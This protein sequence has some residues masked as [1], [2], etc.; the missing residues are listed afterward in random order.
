[1]QRTALSTMRA[2]LLAMVLAIGL[3]PA[4]AFADDSG[5]GGGSSSLVGGTI[6]A[7]GDE[8]S[9]GGAGEDPSADELVENLRW[10]L[11]TEYWLNPS[12]NKGPYSNSASNEPVYGIPCPE[13]TVYT[14][15]DNGTETVVARYGDGSNDSTKSHIVIRH[16]GEEVFDSSTSEGYDSIAIFDEPGFYEIEI[17]GDEYS[18]YSYSIH[19]WDALDIS[20]WAIEF[21]EFGSGMFESSDEVQSAVRVFSGN[22]YT[23]DVSNDNAEFVS[24]ELFEDGRATY[25]KLRVTM[26]EDSGYHGSNSISYGVWKPGVEHST[27]K[28]LYGSELTFGLP[29]GDAQDYALHT[30]KEV[31]VTNPLVR[32]N[33]L[34]L[35]DYR[36]ITEGENYILK[37]YNNVDVGMAEVYAVGIGDFCGFIK[38]TFQIYPRPMEN[39][40]YKTSIDGEIVDWGS[41]WLSFSYS[42]EAIKP[43][44]VITDENGAT[45]HLQTDEQDGDYQLEYGVYTNGNDD[46]FITPG[47]YYVHVIGAGK[48]QGSDYYLSYTI[49]D[50]P[51]YWA[52]DISGFGFVSSQVLYVNEDGELIIDQ[53]VLTDGQKYYFLN[54]GQYIYT[55]KDDQ[56]NQVDTVAAGKTYTVRVEGCA[57]NGYK[58]FVEFASTVASQSLI[59][60]EAC[61]YL[62][63]SWNASNYV[64]ASAGSAEYP[65]FKK[66]GYMDEGADNR[67]VADQDFEYAIY[68][69]VDNAY[70]LVYDNSLLPIGVYQVLIKGKGA[71]GGSTVV[72]FNVCDPKDLSHAVPEYSMYVRAGS[73]SMNPVTSVSI[74]GES[75]AAGNYKVVY[76]AEMDNPDAEG[77]S[78]Y[79]ESTDA[80]TEPG[81]YVFKIASLSYSNE[82]ESDNGDS[83]YHGCSGWFSYEV[84]PSSYKGDLNDESVELDYSSI[85]RQSEGSL[86]P[87]KSI[88]WDDGTKLQA[89]VDYIAEFAVE[90]SDDDNAWSKQVFSDVGDYV[91]RVTGINNYSGELYLHYRVVPSNYIGSLDDFEVTLPGSKTVY[92]SADGNAIEFFQGVNLDGEPLDSKYYSVTYY[93]K[94]EDESLSELDSAPTDVGN[95]TVTISGRDAYDGKYSFDFSIVEPGNISAASVEGGPYQVSRTEGCIPAFV[96]KMDGETLYDSADDDSKNKLSLVIK[97]F[98]YDEDGD[99]IE[100]ETEP[101][102]VPGS[103]IASFKPKA[104]NDLTGDLAYE[105]EVK[106]WGDLGEAEVDFDYVSVDGADKNPIKSVTVDGQQLSLDT[107][108]VLSFYNEYP[109]DMDEKVAQP[110]ELAEG[111]F[112]SD[113]G[114]YWVLIEPTAE[115]GLTGYWSAVYYV[116]KDLEKCNA[117]VSFNRQ[118]YS[119]AA[120]DPKPIVTVDGTQ[121]SYDG[122]DFE[123]YWNV[124]RDI[125]DAGIYEVEVQGYGLYGG[126]VRGTLTV[127]PA[128]IAVPTGRTLTYNAG[129]Q[130]GVAGGAGYSVSGNAAA[131]AGSYTATATCDANHVFSNGSKTVKVGWRINPASINGA[132]V[133]LAAASAAYNG[134]NQAGSVSGVTLGGRTLVNGKD[135]TVSAVRGANVG[136]YAVTVNGKGNYTG[137]KATTFSVTKAGNSA[138]PKK[139]SLKK[140]IKLAKVKKKA[141]KFSLPKVTTKFGKAKWKV[142][143]WGK[144]AK[145]YLKV[146]SGGK[147]TVKKGAMKGT[148]TVKLRANV[149]GTKN[150]NAAKSGV[151]TV[152]VVVK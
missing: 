128:T 114:E 55:V 34:E 54:E 23:I 146:A 84:V 96:V 17:F 20:N 137:S 148:Y 30:G 12:D 1:M 56:G 131:N 124:D 108:Y 73:A 18:T 22:Q 123:Y 125:K 100:I 64:F 116:Y 72:T 99:E 62:D 112:P 65:R 19:I 103:Y 135:F 104:G 130:T 26:R 10:N 8:D 142:A 78:Y 139:M 60:S 48:Y 29:D 143:K 106:N 152:K 147:V 77:A 41:S 53:P 86:N 71:Y 31:Y 83:E 6:S 94:D 145:K 25:Y 129:N 87:V 80:P 75:V 109:M 120:L 37:Y 102:L 13:A 138:K 126:T 45:L 51:E 150:Y 149:A 59:P 151:V 81:P 33:D 15:D 117:T 97:R 132:S 88:T 61:L 101:P 7:M 74:N 49:E 40:T 24:E 119:G 28:S 141:Q 133:S 113:W 67:L 9:D 52:I 2:A 38:C 107:D 110:I 118:V 3:V 36:E 27:L 98:E 43:E 63:D 121:L 58:G 76:G 85:V 140:T 50:S 82:S 42:G 4:L 5:S 144:N 70:E 91:C 92:T 47:E 95:Y 32:Y 111:E 89:D 79:Q 21:K 93:S 46:S 69:Y 16:S 68:R 105:F 136:N 11:E 90:E 57:E 127:S 115:S 14:E 35:G 134:K 122:G 44:P 39:L 66:Y